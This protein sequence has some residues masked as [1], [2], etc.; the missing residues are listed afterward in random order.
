MLGPPSFPLNPQPLYA[1][2]RYLS[3]TN[4]SAGVACSQTPVVKLPIINVLEPGSEATARGRRGPPVQSTEDSSPL[5]QVP[6]LTLRPSENSGLTEGG[7]LVP[8]LPLIPN[9][10]FLKSAQI[11]ALQRQTMK[12]GRVRAQ[13]RQ[14]SPG[15]CASLAA[16]PSAPWGASEASGEGRDFPSGP[17]HSC[18]P[19]RSGLGAS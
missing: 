12:T 3:Q 18:N 15:G 17:S 2:A 10:T 6:F 14:A 16:K 1:G 19:F 5:H 11:L 9:Y 13:G 7:K 4:V 8:R